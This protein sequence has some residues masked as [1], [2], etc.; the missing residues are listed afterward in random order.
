MTVDLYMSL[1]SPPSR[2]V[3]MTAQHIGLDVNKTI[4]DLANGEHLKPEYAK[5]NPQRVVP[6]IV[7][8]GYILWEGRAIQAYLANK[9]APDHSVY[10]KD[11]QARAIVDRMLFFDIGTLYKAGSD[12]F[13]PQMFAGQPADPAKLEAFNKALGLLEDSLSKTKYVAA[14]HITLPDFSIYAG[15]TFAE[16]IDFSYAEFPKISAWMETMKAE[17]PN[18]EEINVKP[19][20]GFKEFIKSKNFGLVKFGGCKAK[21]IV[22]G[23]TVD[24]YLSYA[25]PPSRAVLMTAQHIGVDVNHKLV[26]LANGEH[27]EPEYLK[28]TLNSAILSVVLSSRKTRET[29]TIKMPVDVYL[30]RPSAPCRAVLMTAA[31]VGVSVNVKDVDLWTGEN[32][33]PEFTKMNPQH[34]VPTIDDNGF[35]LWESRAV[36]TYLANKYA[37]DNSVYPKDPQV[38]AA[39]DRML[40]FDIGT[41]YKAEGEY[42]YPQLFAGQAADPVKLE[43]FKKALTLFEE[44]L[45][46]TKYA[47]ADHIT[48]ADFSIFA[49]LTFAEVADFSYAEYP[50]ISAYMQKLKSEVPNHEEINEKP[51]NG[52]RDFLK[53]KK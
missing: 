27:M 41:L 50:K 5:I 15:L 18:N 47:A 3:L 16:V 37:P 46:K 1:P 42:L 26:D 14:D 22:G 39:V 2:A 40:Y 10:P 9:Y 17:V 11:P 29:S 43:A 25:S 32:L 35:I 8:N 23:M 28:G 34:T 33:K 30:A 38:R 6:T 20:L 36:Q 31:Y 13:A 4:V 48:L 7:D 44:L 45:G 21:D 12:F 24:V 19:L 53:S 52:F 51:L 49:S